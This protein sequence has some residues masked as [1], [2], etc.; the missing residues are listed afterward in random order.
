MVAPKNLAVSKTAY[1]VIQV[2]R[3]DAFAAEAVIGMVKST[4]HRFRVVTVFRSQSAEL[5]DADERH[6]KDSLS[7]EPVQDV[8]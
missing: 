7:Y 5:P 8:I 3:K 1:Q 6:M 4:N 2:Y